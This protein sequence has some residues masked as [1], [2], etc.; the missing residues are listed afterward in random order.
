MAGGGTPGPLPNDYTYLWSNSSTGAIVGNTANVSGLLQGCYNVIVTDGNGCPITDAECII[1][2]ASAPITYTHT[3]VTCFG[4]SD[5]SI[6]ITSATSGDS[7]FY[8]SGQ[9]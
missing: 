5:G 4:D 1:S 7:L 3:D 9:R 2:L 8:T 6:T